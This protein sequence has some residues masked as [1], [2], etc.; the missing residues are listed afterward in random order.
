M[1][2]LALCIHKNGRI[3]SVYIPQNNI[4]TDEIELCI[5]NIN[6]LSSIYNYK[7]MMI[8]SNTNG[9][10]IT[11]K[12][13]SRTSALKCINEININSSLILIYEKYNKKQFSDINEKLDNIKYLMIDNIENV[14]HNTDSLE[15]IERKTEEL[16]IASESF[17]NSSRNLKNDI[18]CN[19]IKFKIIVYI[20]IILCFALIGGLAFSFVKSFN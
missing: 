9:L 3:V 2:I 14:L 20:I 18:L 16:T 6:H 8:Y 5:K 4:S 12:D 1:T 13:Y 17:N 11:T 19:D 15:K 7:D 10:L